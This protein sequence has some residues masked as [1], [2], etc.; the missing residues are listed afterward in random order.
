[1]ESTL[2]SVLVIDADPASRNYLAAMLSKSGYSVLTAV[3]GREGLISAWTDQPRIIILDLALTDLS[4]LELVNRLRQDRRT[5][6]VILV[7]LSSRENPQEVAAVLAAGCS[8]YIVKSNQT[9]QKLLELLPHLLIG[10]QNVPKKQG[11]LIVFLSAKGGTG[12]SS[13]CA[14]IAMC[15]ASEKMDKKVAVI[16]LVLPIGSIAHIVGY[17]DRLNLVTAAMLGP[18]QITAAYFKDNLPRVSGWYFHLLAGAP[19]PESANRLPVEMVGDIFKTILESYDFV[20]VDLGRSLSRISLP[21]IQKADV[22]ALI[23]ST[24]LATADLTLT[25]L[26]YLKAQGVDPQRVFP[27]QNRAVGLEGLTRPELEKRI[28]LPIGITMP[29]MGDNFTV[30]NNRHEPLATRLQNDSTILML[31]QAVNQMIEMDKPSHH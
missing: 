30:A 17:T 2:I 27:I 1:M 3:L 19:D 9:I 6:N 8:E 10:E 31:K 28:G 12:T 25:V 5:S 16:D 13:L 26:E 14:N 18:D 24:D 15:L 29:Y 20:F 21:I 22:I 23:L 4:G 7:A 11:K